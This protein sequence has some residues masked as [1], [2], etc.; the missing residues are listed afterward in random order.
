MPVTPHPSSPPQASASTSPRFAY[1]TLITSESYLVG[2]LVLAASLRATGTPH[3]LVC[4]Y[5]PAL[6]PGALDRLRDEYD[7]IV[8]IT[9]LRSNDHANLRLLGRPDLDVTFSKLNVWK[10]T[11][12]AKVVFLDADTLVNEG[13]NID[14]LFERDELSAAPDCGWPDIF[15]S[16]LFVLKPSIATF[17]RLVAFAASR[18]SWDGGD[19]GLLNDFFSDWNTTPGR[20]LPFVYNVTPTSVYTYAPAFERFQNDIKVIHFAGP[21]KPWT[22][23]LDPQGAPLGKSSTPHGGVLHKLVVKW[24]AV[25]S[26]RASDW[27]YLLGAGSY[28][29]LYDNT[30]YT[31]SANSPRFG[32]PIGGWGH[33]A[34]FGDMS[35]SR[36]AHGKCNGQTPTFRRRKSSPTTSAAG[37]KTSPGIPENFAEALLTDGSVALIGAV[38][39]SPTGY[40]AYSSKVGRFAAESQVHFFRGPAGSAARAAICESSRWAKTS[41]GFSKPAVAVPSVAAPKQN[42]VIVEPSAGIDEPLIRGAGDSPPT[43]A[44]T[45]PPPKKSTPSSTASKQ[46]VP[47]VAP[48]AGNGASKS[49]APAHPTTAASKVAAEPAKKE[50][51][52]PNKKPSPPST[53]KVAPAPTP[54]PPKAQSPPT[55]KKSTPSSSASSKPQS[56]PSSKKTAPASTKTSQATTTATSAGKGSLRHH[57]VSDNSISFDPSSPSQLSSFFASVPPSSTPAEL[58]PT[59]SLAASSSQQDPDSDSVLLP[60][61]P[62]S[63]TIVDPSLSLS[64]SSSASSLAKSKSSTSPSRRSPTR[65]GSPRKIVPYGDESIVTSTGGESSM[66]FADSAFGASFSETMRPNSTANKSRSPSRSLAAAEESEPLMHSINETAGGGDD[67]DFGKTI[68]RG[69]M[70]FAAATVAS[71]DEAQRSQVQGTNNT[72]VKS[73]LAV[74]SVAVG[75]A[76]VSYASM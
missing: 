10:L 75:V 70:D 56:P 5:D 59:K 9:P 66:S 15:N 65:T 62:P 57:A 34:T 24:W 69:G 12:Y 50:S 46:A 64:T 41:A 72:Y 73:L 61:P 23:A 27:G 2:A 33:G 11:Q 54:A 26:T 60:T 13:A 6:T 31:S 74:L 53:K 25:F 51:P 43:L 7:H 68:T 39:L 40:V 48:A 52:Q 21:N 29:T 14:D 47:A 30:G 1:A 17:N 63:A 37:G 67:E 4:M 49:S 16:G 45:I 76:V 36:Y 32:G 28:G 35:S 19:Q 55:S 44:K 3:E 38:P 42:N 8:P 20:R 22:Y 71:T 18:G 58:A